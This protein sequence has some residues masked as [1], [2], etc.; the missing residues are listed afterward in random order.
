MKLYLGIDGGQSHT[1]ALLADETGRVIGAGAAGPSN[2]T[3][4]PGGRKR[5]V[6]AVTRSVREAVAA[7]GLRAPAGQAGLRQL[8]FES[9]HLAMTG[10]P[11]DKVAI[12]EQLLNAHRLV[13][14][15]DAP[16]ALAGALA[17]NPGIIVLA[18][19]GS[20]VYGESERAGKR[21]AARVGG[22]GYLFGDYGSAFDIARDAVTSALDLEDM[23]EKSALK[24]AI[25]EFFDRPDLASVI[26]DFYAGAISRDHLAS[27]SPEVSRL[28]DQDDDDA[29]EIIDEACSVLVQMAAI[30]AGRLGLAKM[31]VKV[32]YGGGVFRSKNFVSLFRIQL[33]LLM[34]RATVLAPMFAPDA[35]ALLLAYRNAGVEIDK[36]MLNSLSESL[37]QK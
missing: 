30:A 20:V 5:L 6:D 14:G 25:L 1:S 26:Q 22:H 18:G 29:E 11:A 17:G 19:T 8:R 34:P 37:S 28:A 21:K 24:P 4:E 31:P 3:R 13:V 36:K 32:A 9:A 27:F 35:G 2:H 33:E 23:G 15:H 10:E 16:A 7:A 12:V